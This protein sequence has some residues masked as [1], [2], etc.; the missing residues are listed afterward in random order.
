MNKKVCIIIPAFNEEGNIEAVAAAVKDVFKNLPYD[1][2][3]LFCDDGSTDNTLQVIEA[4]SRQSNAIQ[5][6]SF[7]KNNGHQLALKAGIDHC[8]ADCCIS[9][10][11]DLQ[12]PPGLIP[13]MLHRW[14]Q[15]IEV[16][17]TVRRDQKKLSLFKKISS[18]LFYKLL[19]KLSSIELEEGSADFR[20]LDKKV[21]TQLK[22][23]KEQDIFLRGLVKWMGFRQAA[24]HY[25]PADRFSGTSKYSYKKMLLLALQGITSFSTKPLY[26]AIY[27]GFIFSFLSL[28]YI[29]Y[30]IYNYWAGHVVSGWSSLIVTVT[31]LGGLQLIIMGIIGL[32][33]GKLFMQSKGRPLYIIDKTNIP[34]GDGNI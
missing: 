23:I 24:I 3:I 29:P 34:P 18:S 25:D 7:S 20:L 17:Y 2:S 21:V 6:L 31:F 14:E 33:L 13:Q 19:S 15:G 27:I 4:L 5:Y 12:H 16:V 8:D 9:M 1:Y 26:M 30:A 28:L 11:A 32:Y 22:G 10:D